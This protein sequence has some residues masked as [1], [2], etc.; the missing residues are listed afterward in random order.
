MENGDWER[1]GE[2]IRR[3]VQEAVDSW[4]FSRLNQTITNTIDAAMHGG[5]RTSRGVDPVGFDQDLGYKYNETKEAGRTGRENH[6]SSYTHTDGDTQRDAYGETGVE[7]YGKTTGAKA[8]GIALAIAGGGIGIVFLGMSLMLAVVQLLTGGI[9]SAGFWALI[10]TFGVLFLVG[11]GIAAGGVK[12]LGLVK[13]FRNYQKIL[14]SREY[15]DLKELAEQTGEKPKQVLKDV[16]KMIESGWFSQGRLDAQE[17]CLILSDQAYAQYQSTMQEYQKRQEKSK[18]AKTGSGYEAASGEQKNKATQSSEEMKTE[19]RKKQLSPEA[20]EI[21]RKGE[22][23]IQKIHACND[24][25]PGV[26][27]SAKIARMEMLIGR[28]FDRV[29][30]SPQVA[31]E[32][33]KLMSYYLPTTLKLLEAYEELD[34]QP[35]QGENIASSKREIEETLDTLNAAF[36]KLLDSLFQETAWDVSSDISVLKM[37]LAQEGLGPDDFQKKEEK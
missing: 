15:C 35:V 6:G 25:I 10:V 37:M 27:I 18:A 22:E 5:Q 20:E 26:E 14:G 17:K 33:Q 24:A 2:E 31:G 4:D 32:T 28:I 11:T 16:K 21:V 19:S 9:V 23:Y 29:E 34:R 13:R 36:E 8:G 1:F 12:K 30:Q 3:S 7:L